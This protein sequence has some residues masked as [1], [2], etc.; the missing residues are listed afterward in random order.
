MGAQA[1]V[2]ADSPSVLRRINSAPIL[3]VIRAHGPL[4]RTEI[5]RATRL[6]KP[7]VNDVVGLLWRRRTC[8][9]ASRQTAT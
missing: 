9:R 6:S 2:R 1:R 3:E 5:A 4:S 8:A 7:T